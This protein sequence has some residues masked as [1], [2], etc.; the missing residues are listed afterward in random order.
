MPAVHGWW[1]N[2]EGEGEG[3]G[4][5]W[6]VGQIDFL[7]FTLHHK[8]ILVILKYKIKKVIDAEVI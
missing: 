1:M 7:L 2:G 6:R 3:E 4:R 5:N 8:S